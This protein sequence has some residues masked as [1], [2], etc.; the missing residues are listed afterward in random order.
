MPDMNAVNAEDGEEFDREAHFG[1]TIGID[2]GEHHVSDEH[3]TQAEAE[4]ALADLVEKV[5]GGPAMTDN[6]D[7][8]FTMAERFKSD[9][10][11]AGEHYKAPG[12][13]K[14]ERAEAQGYADKQ[15]DE[16]LDAPLT[17]AY[18]LKQIRS[19]VN[20][21]LHVLDSLERILDANS[22]EGADSLVD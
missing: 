8:R 19:K 7:S 12:Q 14:D 15:A 1:K 6:P 13:S 18:A 20:A 21:V 17:A 5:G 16:S 22:A 2:E 10:V 4:A 3:L 9:W 11:T